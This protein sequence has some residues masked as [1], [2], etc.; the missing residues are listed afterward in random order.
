MFA[1][2]WKVCIP[3]ED[4]FQPL[5]VLISPKDEQEKRESHHSF[6]LYCEPFSFVWPNDSLM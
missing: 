2:P 1:S 5:A 6:V 3:V 4:G